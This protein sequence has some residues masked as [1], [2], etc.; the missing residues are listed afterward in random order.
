MYRYVFGLPFDFMLITSG[1]SFHMRRQNFGAKT[2]TENVMPTTTMASRSLDPLYAGAEALV[3]AH[4]WDAVL[5]FRVTREKER[6]LE[7]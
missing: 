2:P 5:K 3:T 7:T 6:V 1:D 4:Q